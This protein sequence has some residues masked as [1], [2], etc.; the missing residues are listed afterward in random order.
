MDKL[1]IA[2]VNAYVGHRITVRGEENQVALLK[3][4]FGDRHAVVFILLGSRPGEAVTKLAI[5]VIHK[6]GAIKTY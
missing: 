5:Y 1:P 4:I 3:F 6:A 2:Y